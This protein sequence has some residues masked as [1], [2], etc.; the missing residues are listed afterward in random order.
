M[1]PVKILHG[2]MARSMLQMLSKLAWSVHCLLEVQRQSGDEGHA[3]C[4]F[5]RDAA[6]LGLKL[7][8]IKQARQPQLCPDKQCCAAPVNKGH[9]R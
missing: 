4:G 1:Q 9:P 3:R 8:S 7:W 2:N 5:R 6:L